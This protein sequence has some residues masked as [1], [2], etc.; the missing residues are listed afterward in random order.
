MTI[1]K[2]HQARI[3]AMQTLFQWYFTQESPEI[4]LQDFILEHARDQKSADFP[5][6]RQLFLGA[7][8]QVDEI[9]ARLKPFVKRDIR[10]LNP[11]ELSVLRLAVYELENHPEV[12]KKVVINEA[13]ELAKNF[14]AAD[15]Y[16][17][18]NGVL[19]AV[20]KNQINSD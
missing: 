17:F 8:A 19:N 6:F 13:I 12:P 14:G 4:L 11:V 16:K 5:L 2:R 20:I 7:V 9:D 3:F 1:N 10:L 18:V 15:G